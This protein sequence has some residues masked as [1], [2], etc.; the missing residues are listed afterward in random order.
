MSECVSSVQ[1]LSAC[2][3][4]S[5]GGGS[6]ADVAVGSSLQG[7]DRVEYRNHGAAV[8][9]LFLVVWCWARS[10][11]DPTSWCLLLRLLK[12]KGCC[13]LVH[14]KAAAGSEST[15]CMYVSQPTRTLHS[16]IPCLDAT[17]V[18]TALIYHPIPNFT[19][20]E[21][22]SVCVCVSVLSNLLPQS[23]VRVVCI[24]PCLNP[25]ASVFVFC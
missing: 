24:E 2:R 13:F 8:S 15:Q 4:G 20:Q 3:H 10:C 19:F 5:G 17:T 1:C 9:L 22:S 14:Q 7:D 11:W 16:F 23:Y 21:L 18:V 25:R 12:V 6:I